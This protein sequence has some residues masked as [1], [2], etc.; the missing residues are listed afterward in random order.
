MR[1]SAKLDYTESEVYM[2]DME[3]E[4]SEKGKDYVFKVRDIDRIM[5]EIE[6]RRPDQ[7]EYDPD[8]SAYFTIVKK[9]W[10]TVLIRMWE[11]DCD[12]VVDVRADSFY[13]YAKEEFGDETPMLDSLKEQYESSPGARDGEHPQ[14]WDFRNDE[15]GAAQ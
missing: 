6:F 1:Y 10:G 15:E 9:D 4:L 14:A 13:K 12:T 2:L 11:Y 3:V 7:Y 8:S 5:D